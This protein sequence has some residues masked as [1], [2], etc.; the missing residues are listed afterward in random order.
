MDV[1]DRLLAIHFSS[2]KVSRWENRAPWGITVEHSPSVQFHAV[3]SGQCWAQPRGVSPILVE[4]GDFILVAN[5]DACDYFDDPQTPTTDVRILLKSIP[6]GET[7]PF[8]GDGPVTEFVC[9][10]FRFQ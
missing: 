8:P 7:S 3:R 9:G 10:F 2:A 5:G 6:P 1:L 4:T